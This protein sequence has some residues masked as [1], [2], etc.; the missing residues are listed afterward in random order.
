MHNRKR[1][2]RFCN[3]AMI[4]EILRYCSL[5]IDLFVVV[6]FIT[7]LQQ[8]Y[9]YSIS[10]RPTFSSILK[11]METESEYSSAIE[12]G[13]RISNQTVVILHIYTA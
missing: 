10:C 1:K 2:N 4:I 11:N 12:I 9:C 6:V 5:A 8:H 13:A 3:C 7:K